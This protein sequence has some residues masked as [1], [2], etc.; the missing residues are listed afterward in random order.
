MR[1]TLVE[2]NFGYLQSRQG[3]FSSFQLRLTCN[4]SVSKT[5]LFDIQTQAQDEDSIIKLGTVEKLKDTVPSKPIMTES[6]ESVLAGTAKRY[7][8]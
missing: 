7:S 1:V 8:G 3:L 6:T 4:L 5:H 2:D